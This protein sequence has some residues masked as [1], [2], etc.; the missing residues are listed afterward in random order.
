MTMNKPNWESTT[1]RERDA[2]V[3]GKVMGWEWLERSNHEQGQYV[4]RKAIF[5]PEGEEWIRW[6]F[7]P[8]EWRK[9][10]DDTPPFSDWD[11]CSGQRDD[12]GKLGS[13]RIMGLP[14]YSTSIADAWLVVEK[15]RE[16]GHNCQIEASAAQPEWIACFL[17]PH[18]YREGRAPTAP[19]AICLTALRALGAIS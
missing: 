14:H 2:I 11:R 19:A 9:A 12:D 1:T 3:A 4:W 15:M 5:P 8:R 10:S 6:N 16:K 17:T 18:G 7:N 13:K